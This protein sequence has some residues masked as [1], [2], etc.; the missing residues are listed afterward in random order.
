LLKT[1]AF[2]WLRQSIK[3]LYLTF[4]FNFLF[5]KQELGS[6]GWLQ[7]NGNRTL[8]SDIISNP[9]IVAGGSEINFSWSPRV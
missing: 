4:W 9:K 5:Q 2:L 1:H 6:L 7:W 8:F 3:T